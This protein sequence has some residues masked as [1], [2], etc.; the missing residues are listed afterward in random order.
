MAM[1]ER[2]M[3]PFRRLNRRAKDHRSAP[4]EPDQVTE[5]ASSRAALD[6][7]RSEM[8]DAREAEGLGPPRERSSPEWL[9]PDAGTRSATKVELV[10][11][12]IGA[13]I[14]IGGLGLFATLLTSFDF[15]SPPRTD[16]EI[17]EEWVHVEQTPTVDD[18][19]LWQINF[20]L[21]NRTGLVVLIDDI[22]LYPAPSRS[23]LEDQSSI[24][25][26][27]IFSTRRSWLVYDLVNCAGSPTD[28]D[29]HEWRIT[30]RD[31]DG[32]AAQVLQLPV[33]P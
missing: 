4:R 1:S 16:I 17:D 32:G 20:I 30:Y 12:A 2:F 33:E 24:P 19:C 8:A 7:A 3:G 5:L 18:G 14:L 13:I 31:T 9:D 22:T 21:R 15:D 28:L 23:L 11:V 6:H 25:D 26:K 10:G 29:D 27:F